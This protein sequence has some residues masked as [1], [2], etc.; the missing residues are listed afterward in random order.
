MIKWLGE[1][2]CN[3]C[4]KDA[5]KAK[6]FA[7]AK[8]KYGPWALVCDKCCKKHC[9]AVGQMYDPKT[10]EKICDLKQEHMS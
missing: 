5:T 9:I 1:T 2:E 4:H 7:D 3:V 6:W 8:T 10:K